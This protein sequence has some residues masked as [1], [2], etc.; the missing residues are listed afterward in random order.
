M[1]VIIPLIWKRARS[2]NWS[3][4]SSGI[5]RQGSL[6]F[7]RLSISLVLIS[8]RSLLSH[9]KNYCWEVGIVVTSRYV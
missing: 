9:S 6:W 5:E 2:M 8:D 4:P 7:T 3:F 1:V